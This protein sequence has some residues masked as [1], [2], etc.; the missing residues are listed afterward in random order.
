VGELTPDVV[1]ADPARGLGQ[2]VTWRGQLYQMVRQDDETHIVVKLGQS[3]LGQPYFEA[4]SADKEFYAELADYRDGADGTADTVSVVGV[5]AGRDAAATRL[6]AGA[7]L[8]RIRSVERVGSV[9]SRAVVGAN[10][11]PH[12]FRASTVRKGLAAWL[13]SPPS[14]GTELTFT[15]VFEHF[16]E[17]NGELRIAPSEQDSHTA[18]IRFPQASKSMFVD[19]RGHDLVDVVAAVAAAPRF[20]GDLTLDGKSIVR[21]ANPLSRVTDKGR[22]TPA[23]DFAEAKKAWDTVAHE[24]SARSR[25]KFIGAGVFDGYTKG[26][27]GTSYCNVTIKNLFFNSFENLELLC[28]AGSERLLKQLS[29]GDELLF[30]FSASGEDFSPVCVMVW[31]AHIGDPDKK[32]PLV[33]YH[34]PATKRSPVGRQKR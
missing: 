14:V 17:F 9:S 22:E 21:Q 3:S 1:Y 5:V 12:S 31:M 13:K 25:K 19:Y 29:Q 11:S 32:L 7:P 34:P 6:Q 27:K 30:E 8:L 15:A 4:F 20:P 24:K 16:N 2:E 18:T 33:P 28:G 10:R 26:V 23:Q